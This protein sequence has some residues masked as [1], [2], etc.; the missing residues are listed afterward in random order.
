MVDGLRM[1]LNHTSASGPVLEIGSEYRL[2]FWCR[3]TLSAT[4]WRVDVEDGGQLPLNTNDAQDP[5]VASAAQMEVSVLPF[6]ARSPPGSLIR[7]TIQ[8]RVGL[9]QAEVAQFQ[10]ILPIGFVLFEEGRP[11]YGQGGGAGRTV[12][13]VESFYG[14]GQIQNTDGKVFELEVAT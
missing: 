8:T 3:A 10:V 14:E 13:R 7:V 5:A 4:S 6:T 9:G 12:V 11:A 1:T 2:R